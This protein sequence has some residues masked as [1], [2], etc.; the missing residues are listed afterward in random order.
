MLNNPAFNM[1]AGAWPGLRSNSSASSTVSPRV[2]PQ[3]SPTDSPVVSQPV[4]APHV[5]VPLFSIQNELPKTQVD[6][7]LI[8]TQE[9]PE[10]AELLKSP[11]LSPRP[12][13]DLFEAVNLGEKKELLLPPSSVEKASVSTNS[14]YNV[15]R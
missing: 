5:E 15:S 3:A 11:P 9:L 6:Q 2:L 8:P 1:L 12:T 4:L 13:S 14:S 10:A 7:T